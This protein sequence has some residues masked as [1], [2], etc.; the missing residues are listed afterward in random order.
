MSVE[1]RINS[2]DGTANNFGDPALRGSL[3]TDVGT[4][5][6]GIVAADT[7]AGMVGTWQLLSMQFTAPNPLPANV[8]FGVRNY[9]FTANV[10]VDN[11]TLVPEPATLALLGLGALA[12]LGRHRA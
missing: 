11:F 6:F 12:M 9:G 10:S 4:T 1:L 3:F 7:S 5:D 8:N 2:I